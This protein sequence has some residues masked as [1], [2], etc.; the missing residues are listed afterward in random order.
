MATRFGGFLFSCRN[1]AQ[2][3]LSRQPNELVEIE[4]LAPLRPHFLEVDVIP[5]VHSFHAITFLPN[6][7]RLACYDAMDNFFISRTRPAPHPAPSPVN[8]M[9][10]VIIHLG[11]LREIKQ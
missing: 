6:A 2:L 8:C 10:N 3:L 11:A 4:S 7:Y 9:P 5:A 1:G